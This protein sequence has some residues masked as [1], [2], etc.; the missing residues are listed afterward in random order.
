MV[1]Y[2]FILFKIQGDADAKPVLY[3]NTWVKGLDHYNTT[4]MFCFYRLG[5]KTPL[6]VWGSGT[7]RR[8]FIYSVDLARL[9]LWSLRDYDEIEPVI[10]CGE[11]LSVVASYL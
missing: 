3:W 2:C 7:P 5:D 4:H 1:E 11:T 8:Q 6:D 9:I 10:L